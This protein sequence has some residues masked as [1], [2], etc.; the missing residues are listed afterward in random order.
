[1]TAFMVGR[2]V[3]GL[4]VLGV[5]GEAE[6]LTE[7]ERDRVVE[8]FREAL[9]RDRALVVGAGAAGTDAAIHACARAREL[10]ADAL[11]VGPP[12]IQNDT[13]LFGY[14][15]RI[16]QAVAAPIVVHDY[17][18]ATGVIL[19][20][21]LLARLYKELERVQYVKLED[22]PTG[23]KMAQVRSLAGDGFGILGALGGLYALEEL[24]RGAIGIMTGFSYPELL[25]RLYRLYRAGEVAQ[26]ADLFYG[27]LPLIRFEFQPAVGVSLRKTIL[28]RRG[29]I[30]TATVRHPGPAADPV[31]LRQL[32]RILEHLAARGHLEP[33][34]AR[35]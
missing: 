2:G 26:A 8:A 10:G 19:S 22:P 16:A 29:A 11:L 27:I 4:A 33:A 28:V 12:R 17:P 32:D 24:E 34:G 18:P 14:Y 25:V 30:R 1:M 3:D 7:A 21:T 20:P 31:T 23:P 9:P 5:M 35:R 13:V 15:E 6:R